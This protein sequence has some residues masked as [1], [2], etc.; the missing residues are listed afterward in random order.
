MGSADLLG[1]GDPLVR[2]RRRHLD[3]DDGDVRAG[4]LDAPQELGSVL[5]LP[6]H[7]E[8]GIAEEARQPLAEEHRIVGD[9]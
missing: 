9:D 7:V 5:G 3:V 8:A 6:D 1:G 2:V 4:E